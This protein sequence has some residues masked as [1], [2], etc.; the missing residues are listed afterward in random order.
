MRYETGMKLLSSWMVFFAFLSAAE[1]GI[2]GED[3]RQW[4][5]AQSSAQVRELA[6]SVAV[7]I[8][9]SR[10]RN[11]ED[12]TAA[13]YRGECPSYGEEWATCPGTRFNE[14]PSLGACTAFLVG[15]STLF[16]AGHC[17]VVNQAG[18]DG[19]AWVF[20][21]RMDNPEIQVKSLEGSAFRFGVSIPSRLLY[22]CKKILASRYESEGNRLDFALIELDRKVLDREPLP[23]KTDGKFTGNEELFTIGAL[24][25]TFFVSTAPT[26]VRKIGPTYLSGPFDFISKGSGGPFFDHKSGKVV[27]V[28][29][30]SSL[31][32]WRL[33]AEAPRC[34]NPFVLNPPYDEMIQDRKGSWVAFPYTQIL[35]FD[36]IEKNFPFLSLIH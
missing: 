36:F 32:F 23:L 20:D 10:F 17:G 2:F 14:E 29:V 16:T 33:S 3:D 24:G 7:S 21:Y 13:R 12:L 11:F 31:D 22:R 25:G 6:K 30:T 27:G 28:G 1:A 5:N 26:P 4:V 19:S 8:P 15:H 18:C 34:V 35:R 9:R